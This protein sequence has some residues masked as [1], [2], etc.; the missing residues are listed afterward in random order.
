M[1]GTTS[2]LLPSGTCIIGQS[3]KG[4]ISYGSVLQKEEK[5]WIKY[6]EKRVPKYVA[7][8]ENEIDTERLTSR[9]LPWIKDQDSYMVASGVC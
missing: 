9:P 6:M 2:Q 5:R 7:D 4:T 3:G 1:E 8:D